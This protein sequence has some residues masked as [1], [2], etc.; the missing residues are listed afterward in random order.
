[1]HQKTLE[2]YDYLFSLIGHQGLS[3]NLALF[4]PGISSTLTFAS[5]T[6][7]PLF[8]SL[9]ERHILNLSTIALRPAL[10]AIIL[11]ILPGLEEESSEDFD[12]ILQFLN[13]LRENVA[14]VPDPPTSQKDA[15]PHNDSEIG[16][17]QNH[18]I[19]GSEYFWQSLFL[20]SI[21]SPTRR[22]GVLAYLTRHLPKMGVQHAG[23]AIDIEMVTS[24]EPGVLLRCFASGLLDRSQLIQ[25]GFLDLLVTHL[26]LHSPI[27]QSKVNANDLV[28]LVDAAVRVAL[29]R[30]MSLNRRLWTWL[31]GPD[32]QGA[33]DGDGNPSSPDAQSANDTL[34][35]PSARQSTR[36]TYFKTYGVAPLTTALRN[37]I[38]IQSKIPSDRARPFRIALSLM[39]RWEV[40]SALV[41]A[42]FLPLM[43]SLKEYQSTASSEQDFEEV[44]RSANSF[45]DGV[46]GTIVWSEIL[47][48]LDPVS[49]GKDTRNHLDLARFIL[50]HFNVQGED[51]ALHIPL[52]CLAL[53]LFIQK[54]EATTPPPYS[55]K[56]SEMLNELMDMLPKNSP[57]GRTE[58]GNGSAPPLKFSRNPEE[59]L[60][61]VSEFYRR[62]KTRIDLQLPPIDDVLT[63]LTQEIV[64]M[65]KQNLNEELD[66]TLL[67]DR[68]LTLR[69]LL[70]RK[71][72]HRQV[73]EASFADDLIDCLKSKATLRQIPLSL[74]ASITS[75]AT[76]LYSSYR[77]GFF[78]STSHMQEI[79]HHLVGRLWV[80][81]SPLQPQHHAETVRGLW[82]LQ[83][84][85]WKWRA[86]ESRLSDMMISQQQQ[87]L[88][89]DPVK[90]SMVEN[91]NVL[92]TLSSNLN[93]SNREG[94][95]ALKDS[96]VDPNARYS[97]MLQRPLLIAVQS[98]T[99]PLNNEYQSALEWVRSLAFSSL[100][101]IF[102]AFL[103]HNDAARSIDPTRRSGENLPTEN[104]SGQ[105]PDEI[106]PT[107]VEDIQHFQ[108]VFQR[109]SHVLSA[110]S[111]E[112]FSGLAQTHMSTTALSSLQHLQ[113]G[114]EPPKTFFIYLVE[115]VVRAMSSERML[116]DALNVLRQLAQSPA[117]SELVETNID[118]AMIS[119]LDTSITQSTKVQ[120]QILE[121]VSIILKIT[122]PR[123]SNEVVHRR[124]TSKDLV[125]GGRRVSTSSE[126]GGLSAHVFQISEALLECNLK[127]ISSQNTKPVLNKWMRLFCESLP[128][129]SDL[130]FQNLLKINACFCK[131][132]RAA[133][134]ALQNSF[135]SDSLQSEDDLPKTLTTLLTG[136]EACLAYTHDQLMINEESLESVKTPEQTQGFFGTVVSGVFGDR[137]QMRNAVANN[138]L[139]VILCFQDAIRACFAL[140]SWEALGLDVRDVAPDSTASFRSIALKLK[141]RSRRILEGL[142]AAEP[143]ECLE[144]AIELWQMAWRKNSEAEAKTILNLLH[145]L[146]GS[147]PANAIPA[148]FNA[149]YSRTNPTA[150]D[151]SRK[152]S[153]TTNLSDTD[154]MTFLISY[155]R[156]L[157]DDVLEEIWI[158]CTT[159]L[160]DVLGNPMPQR[161][162]LPRLLEFVGIIGSKME[163]T[164][165]GE[166]RKMRK[167]LGV[168]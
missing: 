26:P 12:R 20:A 39:D 107:S 152:S 48:L 124:S 64:R 14:R 102:L 133:F 84:V 87:D 118:A 23:N 115:L 103:V 95:I 160:R 117:S 113:Q 101:T 70:G 150:L 158:D 151:P 112:Q 43:Q 54:A 132:I 138:R 52:V 147:R 120:A 82:Q 85:A 163:N 61:S 46:E 131:E 24:P 21:T 19:P 153:V 76:L 83:T 58:A 126:K 148:I 130:I 135:T 137:N 18:A 78:I 109:I 129:F 136:L 4:L 98:L 119:R 67:R 122:M 6:V 40:G 146:D 29:R 167:E 157:E 8:L 144:T 155:T 165:F 88:D 97:S 22:Q 121:A 36:S 38:E 145:T 65:I 161:Q 2:V 60:A 34:P 80:H 30:D 77:S 31:L 13:R 72:S 9:A 143:L 51:M 141:N 93:L 127:A 16:Q 116:N 56:A 89:S 110:I 114:S 10:K 68:I 1:M 159:F 62:G 63:R 17:V 25:R 53:T 164:N 156:S 33:A 35:I 47:D 59:M 96:Y 104:S 50:D 42:I 81:L 28:V 100:E 125:R 45:F 91:F 71:Q 5:L 86:V 142:F 94:H 105:M 140:W 134:S 49:T 139:T 149:T 92:W 37:M 69:L 166:E 123:R 73:Q 66:G 168:S 75:L 3:A 32:E 15:K 108:W 7:R 99:D 74:L 44:F 106:G 57:L 111:S 90:G 79:V 162:I 128:L 55:Q 27:I 41:S 154:M 11:S